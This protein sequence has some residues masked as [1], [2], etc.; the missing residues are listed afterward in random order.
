MVSAYMSFLR[1]VAAN[2]TW[3]H[4]RPS[5]H[6]TSKKPSEKILVP[7]SERLIL[8]HALNISYDMEEIHGIHFPELK[9]LPPLA[10]L[11]HP[12]IQIPS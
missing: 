11:E 4:P 7:S 9:S 3:V 6:I 8:L 2:H 10:K 1:K 12:I 5:T